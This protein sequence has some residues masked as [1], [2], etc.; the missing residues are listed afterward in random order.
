MSIPSRGLADRPAAPAIFSYNQ[1]PMTLTT[2]HAPF[3]GSVVSLGDPIVS[4]RN[5]AVSLASV[6]VG[7]SA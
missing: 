5:L 6:T 2:P 4:G 1:S 7:F 3:G